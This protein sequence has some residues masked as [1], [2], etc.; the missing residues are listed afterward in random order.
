LLVLLLAV[1]GNLR[2]AD[3][4]LLISYKCSFHFYLTCSKVSQV[5]TFKNKYYAIIMSL[6][7]DILHLSQWFWQCLGWLIWG[8]LNHFSF[9]WYFPGFFFLFLAFQNL[10]AIIFCFCFSSSS[11]FSS[12]L[13]P[14]PHPFYFYVSLYLLFLCQ[15]GN[16]DLLTTP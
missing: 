5:C 3:W 11:I 15:F 6:Q 4:W 7:S 8:Q 10:S 12:S 1:W 14:L 16:L 2:Y 13:P 9:D